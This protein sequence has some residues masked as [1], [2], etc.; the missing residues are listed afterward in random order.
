MPLVG[1]CSECGAAAL[2]A[3]GDPADVSVGELTA[4]ECGECGH[5]ATA[6]RVPTDAIDPD[7][8]DR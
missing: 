1:A 8:V 3:A 5:R 6:Q 7:A 4:V 2:E